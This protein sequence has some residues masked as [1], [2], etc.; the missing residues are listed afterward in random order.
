MKR[1]LL[2]TLVVT[3]ILGTVSA[4]LAFGPGA[5]PAGK[6]D[7]RGPFAQLKLSDEQQQKLLVIRQEFERAALPIRQDMQKKRQE[8]RKLWSANPLDQQAI[9][10]KTKEV[11]A[12]RIQMVTKLRA[13]QEGMKAV[14][15]PEQLKKLEDLK[16]KRQRR[17]GKEF[18]GRD[19]RGGC[20]Q[21]MRMFRNF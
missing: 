18:R 4:A 10:A 11:T 5:G 2:V 21:E 13:M 8:L 6:R 20:G 7:G 15:T 16:S 1:I 9:D 3:L 12:L 17:D 14:L 19:P